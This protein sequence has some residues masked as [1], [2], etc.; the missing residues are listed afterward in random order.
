MLF[1]DGRVL[2]ECIQCGRRYRPHVPDQKF[3]GPACR[4]EARR[5]EAKSA[6]RIWVSAGR[7]IIND[8]RD[9][10]CGQR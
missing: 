10:R 3:C 6:R 8:D 9:L 4:M 2:R 5:R 1:T 7:P